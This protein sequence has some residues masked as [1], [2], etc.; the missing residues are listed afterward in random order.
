MKKYILIDTKN[1]E[2]NKYNFRY[3]LP[4][5]IHINE[6]IKLNMLLIP[7]MSYF[8]NE[9]NNKFKFIFSIPTG[10]ITKSIILPIKNYTPLT[11]CDMINELFVNS[12]F[13]IFKA[14]YDQFNYKITFESSREFKLDLT[15]S[16]FYRIISLD[17]KIYD[18]ENNYI[19]HSLSGFIN[20]NIPYYLKFNIN[21]LTSNNVLNNN[22]SLET[23]WI[24][25]IINKNFGEIIE[26]TDDKYKIKI[27]TKANVNYLDILILDDN[28]KIYDN[29]NYNFFCILEYQ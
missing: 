14:V 24:I 23:S 6:Y 4:K 9:D 16:N 7:R 8:I 15:T 21:N 12:S 11:L 27:D 18:S 13:V 19:N 1:I 29:N 2:D 20:F 17:K 25:P 3:Y 10:F 5:M 22:N 26:Y 28:D